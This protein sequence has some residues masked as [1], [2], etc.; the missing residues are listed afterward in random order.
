MR[1]G[2]WKNRPQPQASSDSFELSVGPKFLDGLPGQEE[3]VAFNECIEDPKAQAFAGLWHEKAVAANGVPLR[4][5]LS[6]AELVRFGKHLTLYKLTEED[7]WL[8]T[9][10]GEEVTLNVGM[11]LTGKHLDEYASEETLKF[12]MDNMKYIQVEGAPYLEIFRLDYAGK[13][14]MKCHTLNLPLRSG[15]QKLPDMFVCYESYM[16]NPVS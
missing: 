5:D 9:F 12:W 16:K 1:S 14:F 15:G 10:C 13:P 7:R 3:W 4:K 8:T 6:F 11:E 2:T